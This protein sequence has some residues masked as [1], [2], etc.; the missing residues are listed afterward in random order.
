MSK[1]TKRKKHYRHHDKPKPKKRKS[2]KNP[3]TWNEFVEIYDRLPVESYL[4]SQVASEYFSHCDRGHSDAEALKRALQ[5]C[6]VIEFLNPLND[7]EYNQIVQGD[8]LWASI[9]K[10]S[11]S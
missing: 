7:E 4:R 2:P 9:R 8:E 3:T 11:E 10:N 5:I 1:K 6:G